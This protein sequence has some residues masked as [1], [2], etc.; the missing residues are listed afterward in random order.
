[1]KPTRRHIRITFV[2]SGE[3]VAAEL[4][5]DEAPSVCQAVWNALPKELDVT[6]AMYSGQEVYVLLD[7]LDTPHENLT[8]IPL[9]GELLYFTEGPASVLAGGKTIG[10]IC[11][12]YGRGVILKQQEGAPTYASLFARVPGD[13]KYDWTDFAQACRR[14]RREGSKKLRIERV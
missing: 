3:S 6:H 5:D 4:L 7:P 12:I 13:W 11:F 1:M 8:Q 14:A 2:G 9:P 10:E